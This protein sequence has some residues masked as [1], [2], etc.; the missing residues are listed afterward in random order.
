MSLQ[1]Q[2]DFSPK[3]KPRGDCTKARYATE[4]MNTHASDTTPLIPARRNHHE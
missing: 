1:S 2:W 3:L 4:S